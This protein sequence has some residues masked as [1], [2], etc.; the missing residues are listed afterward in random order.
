MSLKYLFLQLRPKQWTKN[1][2][3][4]AAFVFS[5]DK[6]AVFEVFDVLFAFLLFCTVSGCVYIFNDF[7]DR[8]ADR[9]HPEK[10]NRPIASG[11]LNPYFAILV[12]S[13]IVL[14]S[15]LAAYLLESLFSLVLVIYFILNLAY[16]IKLKHVVI[17]DIM[18]I[19]TGFVL[20]ALA[21]GIVIEVDFT[22]WFLIC[23]F[24]LSMLLAIGKRRH[25][26]I[27]LTDNKESHRKVLQSYSVPLLD[28][29]TNVVVT[30]TITSYSIFTFMS[31]RTLNLMWT[32]PIVMY[33]VF[34]YLYVVHM[35]GKGGKPEELLLQ[36]KGILFT[37]L[38]YGMAVI[39]IIKYL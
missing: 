27:L 32:I 6:V 12:G 22:P 14:C 9:N 29:M 25:E 34:R 20:R 11:K 8:E 21:G 24:L 18:T 16:S 37:V 31:G 19:A 26:L 39:V 15:F 10:K 36:D 33:G 13:I 7:M 35:H 28:Q 3:V 4:F 2:L 23:V 38:F 1:L 30:A 17:I 5:I